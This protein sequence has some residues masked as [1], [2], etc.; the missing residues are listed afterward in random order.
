MGN[1]HKSQGTET[2][3]LESRLQELEATVKKRIGHPIPGTDGLFFCEAYDGIMYQDGCLNP[4]EDRIKDEFE[5]LT[6]FGDLQKLN[7]RGQGKLK[8]VLETIKTE[9]AYY[10]KN[11]KANISLDGILYGCPFRL[12]HGMDRHVFVE[13]RDVLQTLIPTMLDMK[14]SFPEYFLLAVHDL[15]N[16]LDYVTRIRKKFHEVRDNLDRKIM[17]D[18]FF[19]LVGMMDRMIVRSP[20]P[21]SKEAIADSSHRTELK[22]WLALIE[23]IKIILAYCVYDTYTNREIVMEIVD[24]DLKA[25]ARITKRI[26]GI[27]RV[28]SLYTFAVQEIQH[29]GQDEVAFCEASEIGI[30]FHLRRMS[31]LMNY[32]GEDARHHIHTNLTGIIDRAMIWIA[33]DRPESRMD[34]NND[35]G[36]A[37][38]GLD[39]G[40]ITPWEEAISNGHKELCK[41]RQEDFREKD[42]FERYYLYAPYLEFESGKYMLSEETVEEKFHIF[43]RG[44]HTEESVKALNKIGLEEMRLDWSQRYAAKGPRLGEHALIN[45]KMPKKTKNSGT[46]DMEVSVGDRVAKEEISSPE[47]MKLFAKPPQIAKDKQDPLL[48]EA[49][50][51]ENVELIK[52]GS[53]TA[54]GDVSE[55][56]RN[57]FW[58]FKSALT[59]IVSKLPIRPG[60]PI[61]IKPFLLIGPPG[62]GKS[63]LA[64]RLAELIG[65]PHIMYNVAGISDS[66]FIGTSKQW[67][68]ARM[69]VPLQAIVKNHVGNPLVILDE[70]DKA[71]SS[72]HNGSIQTGLLS[73]LEKGTAA[74]MLD[75]G[76]E[77]Q[78][79]L[80]MVNYIATANDLAGIDP[81]LLDRFDVIRLEPCSGED[82]WRLAPTLLKNF[83]DVH[84]DAIYG[85][86]DVE[87]KV[88]SKS[89]KGGSIRILN[90]MIG[91]ILDLRYKTSTI[92]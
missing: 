43:R 4:F 62:I 32:V 49:A 80:S 46:G 9:I 76:L 5:N 55:K 8:P 66:S 7:T 82:L 73:F 75:L 16:C 53:A 37:Q 88:L 74:K 23:L 89:W 21:L 45:L 34:Q 56:L 84:P 39:M 36:Y 31:H 47:L 81:V 26:L 85:L 17:H 91:K 61:V 71:G 52:I 78:A 14:F 20:S 25:Y 92:N 65:L 63:Q 59:K 69:S 19:K 60:S 54:I 27:Y 2:I 87:M 68:S 77:V 35:K 44:S 13:M 48:N 57:E 64:V 15:Y 38:C 79:D 12:D 58:Y 83:K 33:Y 1:D 11:Q 70:L 50:Q 6:W 42:V 40:R 86:T 67:G 28:A 18:K 90:R 3:R 51:I 10:K 22:I 41:Y 29:I 30:V 72:R 24:D